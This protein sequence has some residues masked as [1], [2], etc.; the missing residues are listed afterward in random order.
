MTQVPIDDVSPTANH[1]TWARWFWSCARELDHFPRNMAQAAPLILP[2]ALVFLPKLATD[3]VVSWLSRRGA[4]CPV[5]PPRTRLKGLLVAAR[6]KGLIFVDADVTEGDARFTIAHEVA[7]FM[8]HHCL[9]RVRAVRALGRDIVP[10]LDGDRLPTM[11]ERLTSVIADVPLGTYSHMDLGESAKP[12]SGGNRHEIEADLLAFELLAPRA[13]LRELPRDRDS[14]GAALLDRFGFPV[15][16][17]Q[18]Y[19]DLYCA[20]TKPRPSIKEWF[21]SP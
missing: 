13:V 1:Q 15:W 18:A 7:H 8:L 4:A 21:R 17:A 5:M 14:V 6:N 2:L 20:Q 12:V 16:A 10:V 11:G 9:P 19:A 3:E